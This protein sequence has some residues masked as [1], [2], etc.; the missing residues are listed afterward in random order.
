MNN[1]RRIASVVVVAMLAA[2]MTFAQNHKKRVMLSSN[3]GLLERQDPADLPHSDVAPQTPVRKA[4]QEAVTEL[5]S[6]GRNVWNIEGGWELA[7]A[8]KLV[9]SGNSIFSPD[10][11]TSDWYNAVVPGTVLTTLV[12]QGVYPDPYYGLNNLS[13][14]ESLCRTDWWYRTA[15][16]RPE[17][18][19]ENGRFHLR[20][21]GVNYR[22][23]VW[24]N[25]VKLGT[26][27]GAFIRGVF[28]VTDVIKE[29]NVLAVHIYPPHNPGIPHEESPRS[30][31][32]PNGGQLCLDGPTFISSEGWDWIPGIR[33]RNIGIWQDVQ[34]LATGGV[35]IGDVQVVTDLLLPELA[36]ADLTVKGSLSN[37]LTTDQK[38]RVKGCI[39]DIVFEKELL[40]PA[41]SSLEYSFTPA[42]FASLRMQNPR[43]WWPN[44]YGEQNL[45][46][47]KM[48]VLADGRESDSRDVRFGIRELSYEMSVAV[49]PEKIERIEYMPVNDLKGKGL[50]DNVDRVDVGDGVNVPTLCDGVNPADL[51]VIDEDGTEKYLV[52]KVNGVR[53]FCR[54][55]NWGMDDG[56]KRVS[57][58][59]LEPYLAL[60]KEANF[61]MV[62]NWTGESTEEVFYELCDE[63]GMLVWNDFWW[64]TEGYNL[65]PNDE[66]LFMENAVDAVRRFRNHPSIAVWCP[67]NEGYA[68][69]TMEPKLTDMIAR[70]DGT[71][72]YHGNSRYLNTRPSGPWHY[73]P[74]ERYFKQEAK[75]FNTELG[76]PS[77][78]TAESMRKMMP[79]QDLWPISDTW[80]YHDLH[81]GQKEYCA[82]V[83]DLYGEAQS[84]ED[85]CRKVQFINYDSHRAMFEAWNSKLW[86]ST[87]GVLLWMTHPAWP[88]TVWQVYSW[89]YETFGSFFGCRKA[90]EPLHIQLNAD[91]MK[92]CVINTTREALK[93]ASA[94]LRCYDLNGKL[95]HKREV[96]RTDFKA[97]GMTEC[98]DSEMDALDGVYVARLEL[99]DASGKVVSVN[100]YLR[101]ASGDFKAFNDLAEVPLRVKG[102]RYSAVAEGMKKV[103]FTLSNPSKQAAVAVKL[104]L[105]DSESGEVIL[106][107]YFSDGYF[108]LLP[109]ESRVMS[110]EYPAQDGVSLRFDGYNVVKKTI[111]L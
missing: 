26:I 65:N 61:N 17:S 39:E 46:D 73:I 2:T 88:S 24:L 3:F 22:A 85:F 109:G 100:D 5:V 23:D 49:A 78:P 96:R 80:Y 28:D 53:I 106:P 89:D 41:E 77:V 56:M 102:V 32:G 14:P 1:Y 103:S 107:A 6:S 101:S 69:L 92:V 71:R 52:I 50:F 87:S 54:G 25:G 75:G 21:N 90:C 45:Y 44:G 51:R 79:E 63:Y 86:N 62:R 16:D 105:V 70:E 38:V 19:I 35:T 95:L 82:A 99:K 11:N 84:L 42:E 20:F 93:G 10:F 33:D 97:N 94:S 37:I 81:N 13:I 67:R 74:V 27:N 34:L 15:F 60:H 58:E 48:T 12:E 40:V 47:L 4:K 9:T 68:S 7:E 43:L 66:E 57:R 59:R 31:Q 29:K 55:G 110:V 91:D 72:L 30:G 108:N 18:G 8:D 76:T 104:N 98:F 111:S 36:Y 64:S 83:N